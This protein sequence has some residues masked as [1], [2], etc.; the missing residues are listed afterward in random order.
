MTEYVCVVKQGD[1]VMRLVRAPLH[2][3]DAEVLRLC[4]SAEGLSADSLSVMTRGPLTSLDSLMSASQPVRQELFAMPDGTTLLMDTVRFQKV[5]A[6]GE[7][8]LVDQTISQ[9]VKQLSLYEVL[10]LGARLTKWMVLQWTENAKSRVLSDL[11][12]STGDSQIA[13]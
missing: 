8:R 2:A 13:T 5:V 9:L 10:A 3:T 4:A 1:T 11:D 7:Q 6:G 12:C